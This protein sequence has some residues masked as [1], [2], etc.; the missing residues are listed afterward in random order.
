MNLTE[1]AARHPDK[2][3]IV[4]AGS[5][6]T[7]TYG[8]L[9]AAS[10]RAARF[11]ADEGL[12]FKD[13]V[14]LLYGNGLAFYPAA[15]A[16][17]RS[18][19]YW[20]PVNHH[21]T[22]EEAAYIVADCGARILL[23][24]DAFADL[25]AE[26]GKAV[27][28]VRVLTASALAEGAAGYPAEAPAG[29]REGTYM[30]YSSGT[31][32]RPK[33]I[34]P[35]LPGNP[36]GTGLPIDHNLGAMFGFGADTVYLCPA[37]VYHAAPAGWSLGTVRNG[38]TVVLMERFDP[39]ETLAAIERHRVTHA[40]FV[41]TMLI[42]MLKLSGRGAYDVT[43]L[44]VVVHAAAP[45]PPDIKRQVIDWFGPIVWEY[46]SGSEGNCFF[47]IGSEDWLAHPGSVGR[48]TIGT[49]HVCDDLGREMPVGEVGTVWF[50]GV[51]FF[52]YHNDPGRTVEA[53]NA[54]G[55]ST[56]GDV[57]RLDADGYL[58]LVDRRT[59]LIISG[60][61]NIYPQEIEN[62]LAAHPAVLDVAIVGLPDED[63]GR[64][65]HALVQPVD[66]DGAGPELAEELLAHCAERLARFKTPRSVEFVADLPRTPTG[67]LLRRA[68]TGNDTTDKGRTP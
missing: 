31:T 24:D 30:F 28:G 9:D 18:G 35:A 67:K 26:I 46:Y 36:F 62:V 7:L 48:A 42:R 66:P 55:W 8:E 54:R 38:G 6:E 11:L 51:P 14:A 3:A 33:G 4:M 27:P 65:V 43:S 50:E 56:L 29:E 13:H 1:I 32:G 45:C 41:P 57:G 20:T 19:L 25:A 53:H 39:A 64:R 59:D 16:C 60:G 23:A 61:V 34:L 5:G 37:P 58:Y 10:V 12:S 15:W 2:P 17:Q 63:L 47:L 22:V 52:A 44:R 21:L 49:A 68:L 40:Q